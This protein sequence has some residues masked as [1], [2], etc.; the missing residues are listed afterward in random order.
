MSPFYFHGFLRRALLSTARA[1]TVYLLD[2]GLLEYTQQMAAHEGARTA[3]LYDCRN[4]QV[5]LDQ[6][7]RI[8]L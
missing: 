8:V 4:N 3:K 6:V 1:P 5:T 7:E 2:G